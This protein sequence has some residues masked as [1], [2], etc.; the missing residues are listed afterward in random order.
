MSPRCHIGILV[1]KNDNGGPNRLGE[2]P[3]SGLLH[4]T[5]EVRADAG[6]PRQLTH[7]QEDEAAGQCITIAQQSR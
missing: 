2:A 6:R 4:R 1:M 3:R 7:R 5:R